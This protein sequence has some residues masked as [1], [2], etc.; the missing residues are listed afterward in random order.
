[1]A[2]R[3]R[4]LGGFESVELEDGVVVS[5]QGYSEFGYDGRSRCGG[6]DA[7]LDE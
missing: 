1:M 2:Q 7:G 5:G 3:G 6:G 4:Y